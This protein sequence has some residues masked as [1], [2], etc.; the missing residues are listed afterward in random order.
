[1]LIFVGKD[2]APL[3][4]KV[5]R[6]SGSRELDRSAINAAIQWRFLPGRKN[7]VATE[8]YA[9]V[10]VTFSDQGIKADPAWTPTYRNAPIRSDDDPIPYA[11][12]AEAIVGVAARAHAR[13]YDSERQKIHVYAIRDDQKIVRELWYF[14]DAMTDQAMAVRYIFAGKPDEPVTLV[15]TLCNNAAVCKRREPWVK[16]G[17]Y[18]KRVFTE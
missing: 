7:G 12:V 2:G 6:S 15:A 3:D 10:P 4:I 11:T 13:V 5:D 14:T 17:P 8:G 16:A 18:T 9:R 1:M